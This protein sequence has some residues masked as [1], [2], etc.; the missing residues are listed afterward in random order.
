MK[1]NNRN[2]ITDWLEE[3]GDPVIERMVENNF[4]IIKQIHAAMDAKGIQTV[5]E[6]ATLIGKKQPQ[7]ARMMTGSQ[8]FGQKAIAEIELALDIRIVKQQ[9]SLQPQSVV[10]KLDFGNNNHTTH[11]GQFEDLSKNNQIRSGNKSNIA[12]C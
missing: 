2:S 12:S 3:H 1:K 9:L 6:L 8:N 11:G 10:L 7:I 5:S 4:H